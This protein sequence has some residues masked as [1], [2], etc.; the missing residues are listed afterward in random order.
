M[1]K[2]ILSC[3]LAIG[4]IAF[5]AEFRAERTNLH[6]PVIAAPDLPPP[7]CLPDCGPDKPV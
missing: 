7:D 4:V 5:G 6:K 2:T 1:K 3:A